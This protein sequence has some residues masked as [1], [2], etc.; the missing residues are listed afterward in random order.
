MFTQLKRHEHKEDTSIKKFDNIISVRFF[1]TKKI[2][3][4]Y[5]YI[6]IGKSIYEKIG[7]NTGDRVS[8][9]YGTDNPRIWLIKKTIETDNESY[10]TSSQKRVSRLGERFARAL[11][12]C[13]S[14]PYA[15]Q[16]FEKEIHYVR[17]DFYEGGLRIFSEERF[18]GDEGI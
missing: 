12:I 6:S 16:E 10:K 2:K 8:F 17:Y 1:K 5:T 3:K 18:D 13:L 7:L 9:F 4:Y 15:P 11:K 14:L